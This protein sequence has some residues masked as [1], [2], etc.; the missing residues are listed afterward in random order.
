MGAGLPGTGRPPVAK[1]GRVGD[2]CVLRARR[3]TAYRCA[4]S[5][6]PCGPGGVRA[7]PKGAPGG[8]AQLFP[9][10]AP[11]ALARAPRRALTFSAAMVW[12]IRMLSSSS[13]RR[14]LVYTGSIV[15]TMPKFS[16]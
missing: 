10:A 12:N 16:E 8:H 11:G 1:A 9:P 15:S 4:P 5:Q 3:R 2:A 14:R 7:G 13:L 6:A